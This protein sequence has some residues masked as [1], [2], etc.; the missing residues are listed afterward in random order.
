MNGVSHLLATWVKF[1][2]SR[3]HI[4]TSNR[5]TNGLLRKAVCEGLTFLKYA[6]VYLLNGYF[7]GTG[8]KC[9]KTMFLHLSVIAADAPWMLMKTNGVYTFKGEVREDQGLEPPSLEQHSSGLCYLKHGAG[10]A[11]AP[12]PP[13]PQHVEI[14][15]LHPRPTKLA[16][17]LKPNLLVICKHHLGL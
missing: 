14:H 7:R 11:P 6:F 9:L 10:R 16:S 4:Y 5:N 17:T 1:T 8:P 13:S 12:Q 15:K 2:L 3:K